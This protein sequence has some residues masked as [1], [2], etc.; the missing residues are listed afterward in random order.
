MP[1]PSLVS[2]TRAVAER[3]RDLARLIEQA[4]PM[5]LPR[6]RN[7][8][9]FV[10]LAESICYQQL[11]GRAAAAIWGRVSALFPDGMTP[12]SVA[13]MPDE[14][15]RV[16][17]LSGAKLASIKDL[18]AKVLDG[19]VPLDR[20]ARLPDA[21]VIERLSVVRGIGTWTAEMFLIF[22]LRRLDVWPVDDYGVRAGW[23]LMKGRPEPPKPRDLEPEGERFR[24][25]RTAVAWY[26][27]RAVH[28]ARGQP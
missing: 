25:Y 17:G 2:A 3:D 23:A 12:E 7:P 20:I 21:A 8:D 28:L 10:E 6:P 4:G 18:A 24:P 19:T 26:C 15:L 11:A 13:A 5:R 14:R 16:A 22:T 1:R 9:R 27:W